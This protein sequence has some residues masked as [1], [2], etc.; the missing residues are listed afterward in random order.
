MQKTS[1]GIKCSIAAKRLW[2][3][4]SAKERE[5]VA[6]KISKSKKLYHATPEGKK[7]TAKQGKEHS[8]RMKQGL[9]EKTGL[10]HLTTDVRSKAAKK[11]RKKSRI[12]Y[13]TDPTYGAERLSSSLWNRPLSLP[14]QQVRDILKLMDLP[15]EY[16]GNG[17]L[18]I[19]R[20]CPDFCRVDAKAVI[21]V[22]G[23]THHRKDGKM[24]CY[25]VK[26]IEYIKKQGFSVLILWAE[27]LKNIGQVADKIK[28]FDEK[29][30]QKLIGSRKQKIS[31]PAF[32]GK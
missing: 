1:K 21:D 32:I 27:E 7:K 31:F 28:S 12:L 26:R 15:Y 11:A 23:Y 2:K 16:V 13:K 8:I 10:A 3:N 30:M 19:G 6:K 22:F 20:F 17:R 25:D 5:A 18:M 29:V 14:E 9:F 24:R 4:R